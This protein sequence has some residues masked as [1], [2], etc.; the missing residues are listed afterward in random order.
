MKIT[1]LLLA[2][3]V[4]MANLSTSVSAAEMDKG[5]YLE[6]FKPANAKLRTAS[7]YLRTGNIDF[8]AIALEGIIDGKTP[9]GFSGSLSD[10]IA[11]TV[12]KSKAAL[13]LIDENQEDKARDML[14]K[15]RESL[16]QSNKSA[17]VTVF[18]DCIWTLIKRGPALWTYR[19][20][21][22]D[23]NDPEQ[24]KAVA[25]AASDYLAQLDACDQKASAELKADQDYQRLV[26][27]ARQSLQRI[28]KETLANRDGGQLFRFLIELRSF[29]RLLYF[30][31]G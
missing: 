12:A 7:T 15:L 29:D 2:A 9:S 17:N 24:V 5:T 19:K 22:P 18:D 31:F 8:A 16:F 30:R 10:A 1:T 25:K 11:N 3:L 23:L 14:L 20:N 28:P 13:A 26:T 27:G 6:W 21:K 4:F